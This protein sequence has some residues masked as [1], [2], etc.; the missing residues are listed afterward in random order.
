MRRRAN[1]GPAAICRWSGPR[2][3]RRPLGGKGG[4]YQNLD[5]VDQQWPDKGV[6]SR[7]T[8]SRLESNMLQWERV[9]SWQ[10]FQSLVGLLVLHR[11]PWAFH[12]M[13]EGKDGAQDVISGDR[14]TVYQASY[15]RR[16]EA[17]PS[18]V[19][20]ARRELDA[21]A[22][23]K[24]VGHPRY[25]QWAPVKRWVLVRN[26]PGNASDWPDWD[27]EIVPA[28]KTI[29]I[30]AEL[31]SQSQLEER[32]LACPD[33]CDA[34]FENKPRAFL[35][36]GEALLGARR[37][38]IPMP[39]LR[40]RDGLVVAIV[41]RLEP[42]GFVDVHG[43]LGIGTSRLAIAVAEQAVRA[44]RVQHA[45]LVNPMNLA[46]DGGERLGLGRQAE[47]LVVLDNLGDD[48]DSVRAVRRLAELVAARGER[49]RV[50]VSRKTHHRRVARAI[51]D[52]TRRAGQPIV[53]LALTDRDVQTVFVEAVA[54]LDPSAALATRE[55]EHAARAVA[56]RAGGVPGWAVFAARTVVSGGALLQVALGLREGLQGVL[57][58]TQRDGRAV[59][60]VLRHI[61]LLGTLDLRCEVQRAWVCERAGRIDDIELRA[62]IERLLAD[63]LITR[64]ASDQLCSISSR[65]LSDA[66][67]VEWLTRT[68]SAGGARLNDHAIQ[69]AVWLATQL[70]ELGE[71]ESPVLEPVLVS[72]AGVCHTAS[73]RSGVDEILVRAFADAR[74]GTPT[75]R[76]LARQ[77]DLAKRVAFFLPRV[78]LQ[79]ASFILRIR[80]DQDHDAPAPQV[81]GSRFPDIRD[82]VGRLL[83]AGGQGARSPE[84]QREVVRLF[85]V[86]M[87]REVAQE[88]EMRE[89][90]RHHSLAPSRS[91]EDL[92][93]Q[94]D[95]VPH[96][97]SSQIENEA[98]KLIALPDPSPTDLALAEHVVAPIIATEGFA[99]SWDRYTMHQTRYS[100]GPDTGRG[101]VRRNLLDELW[102]VLREEPD[103]RWRHFAWDT[104]RKA[105][106]DATPDANEETGSTGPLSRTEA[107]LAAQ[108]HLGLAELVH[109]RAMWSFFLRHGAEYPVHRGVAERCEHRFQ[110]AVVQDPLARALLDEA[111]PREVLVRMCGEP[112]GATECLIA[113]H[114]LAEAL[115]DDGARRRARALARVVGESGK[116][117]A[118]EVLRGF[119][120]ER[121]DGSARSLILELFRAALAAARFRGEEAVDAFWAGVDAALPARRLELRRHACEQFNPL[122]GG[123]SAADLRSLEPF[124]DQLAAVV[125]DHLQRML[126][127]LMVLPQ[128]RDMI[129]SVW[130]M[131]PDELHDRAFDALCEGVYSATQTA[132]LPATLEL[133]AWLL[134][135]LVVVAHP[136]TSYGEYDWHL[137]QIVSASGKLSVRW[138]RAFVEKRSARQ[139]DGYTVVPY[140]FSFDHFVV[141]T[142]HDA[143]DLT[144][145]FELAWNERGC[146]YNTPAWLF[147]LDQ[148]TRVLPALLAAQIATAHDHHALWEVGAWVAKYPDVTDDWRRLAALVCRACEHMEQEQREHAYA[149][150]VR[151]QGVYTSV[152]GQLSPRAVGELREAKKRRDEETNDDLRAFRAWVVR[153]AERALELEQARIDE[154]S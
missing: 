32:L 1:L 121:W 145:L 73:E 9:T 53:V 78:A 44:G 40:G 38:D 103:S 60:A 115:G 57:A 104:V 87:R 16:A 29:G 56:R 62:L 108:P 128:T 107:V 59:I 70:G 136:R 106:D 75:A 100:C 76:S 84:D 35:T 120:Q 67:L 18:P 21:I 95:Q 117:E 8:P 118:V 141:A 71:R 89:Q 101:R 58:D 52:T 14:A 34:T 102:R 135:Q 15:T 130:S 63:G 86:A 6:S 83:F 39:T 134:E 3:H 129:A 33:L 17:A 143:L 72:L 96:D 82:R 69:L 93:E 91:F 124:L 90:L 31:W 7:L 126:G 116:P 27:R 122:G 85:L 48:D 105:R 98:R 94:I 28:F 37:T 146:H 131:M 109:A 148:E 4:A 45:Y 81:G 5:P 55:I 127:N 142:P 12:S 138:L 92:V 111:A 68:T 42:G 66:T 20:K 125:P 144:K 51:H 137:H 74:R 36:L 65:V 99:I 41:D 110:A 97:Y 80:D 11:D 132:G 149:G 23:Y 147:S 77:M 140:S 50:L 30:E 2:Q 22:K 79:L 10:A 43:G 153:D 13:V 25:E 19:P 151:R 150:L 113:L 46:S 139:R 114:G 119:E 26:V 88:R 152:A 47:V 154:E 61:A 112:A 133:T 123:G 49:W 24:I 64:R 54:K